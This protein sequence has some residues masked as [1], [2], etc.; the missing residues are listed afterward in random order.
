LIG[1]SKAM[2]DQTLDE[3]LL[4]EEWLP[5]PFATNYMAS[6][7]GRIKN[8]R[9]KIL[10]PS[11]NHGMYFV[12][13]LNRTQY[14]V[15]RIIC[16]TFHGPPPSEI[17]HAAH[18]DNDRLNNAKDNLYWATPKQN[19]EDLAQSNNIKGVANC[20]NALTEDD[21]RLIRKLY[22]EG[23]KIWYIWLDYYNHLSYATIRH[24]AVGR[25]W[26]HIT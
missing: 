6:T 7:G 18:K 16:H 1:D 12:C 22:S 10:R 8:S 17:Y 23:C 25:T 5:I 4:T 24:A 21:V 11:V 9:G 13:D 14:R 3:S 2:S 15:N 26:R 19:G 20:C